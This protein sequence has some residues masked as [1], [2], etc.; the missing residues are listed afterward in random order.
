M[1]IKGNIKKILAISFWGMMSIGILVLL[2]AAIKKRNSKT[3][4]GL[5]V[6]IKNN[7]NPVFI[8]KNDIVKLLS[9]TNAAKPE[10]KPM[11]DISLLKLE[12]AIKKNV[13]VNKVE[14]FFDNNDILQITVVQREPVA[15]VFTVGG[16]N[17]YIDSSGAQLPLIE[18]AV[19]RLPVFTGYPFEKIKNTGAD[20]ILLIQIKNLNNYLLKD[21]FWSAQIVQVDIQPDQTFA[22]VPLVGNHLIEFGDG[23]DLEKKFNRLYIFYKEVLSK[24]G[25]DKYAKV[26]VR[27]AGQVVGT[28]KGGLMTKADSLQAVKNIAMLIKSAQELQADTVK[29]R[30]IRP[31]ENDGGERIIRSGDVDDS[32]VAGRR[33]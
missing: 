6:E 10:G 4:K 17:F 14:A 16:N 30:N 24:T 31:L 13:W 9:G 18:K 5:H 7:P 15:R 2:V 11:V 29:Q 33:N 27:F 12:N 22:L 23:Y 20:S 3:C 28:K 1:S 26:D 25:F 19:V 32:V 8:D 21:A